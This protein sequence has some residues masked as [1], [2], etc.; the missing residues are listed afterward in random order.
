MLSVIWFWNYP[1]QRWN[2]AAGLNKILE[3]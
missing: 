3:P 1:A 2:E